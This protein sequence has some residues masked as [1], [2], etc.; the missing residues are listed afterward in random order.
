MTMEEN[1]TI[2]QKGLD[3]LLYETIRQIG[4]NEKWRILGFAQC[5]QLTKGTPK[6]G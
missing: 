1:K 6:A 3:E 4:E 2:E 5:L